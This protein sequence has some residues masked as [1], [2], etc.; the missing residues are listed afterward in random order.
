MQK[1]KGRG[2]AKGKEVLVY[3][4]YV[5]GGVVS[6]IIPFM[7]SQSF[8]FWLCEKGLIAVLSLSIY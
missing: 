1:S 5:A 8:G 4:L 2:K 7:K 3:S 6:F